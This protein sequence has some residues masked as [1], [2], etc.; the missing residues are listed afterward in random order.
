M[1]ALLC[2]VT[3]AKIA[4][5]FQPVL[6]KLLFSSQDFSREELLPDLSIWEEF[7]LKAGHSCIWR[8][9]FSPYILVFVYIVIVVPQH[10]ECTI[11]RRTSP[12]ILIAVAQLRVPPCRRPRFEPV[13]YLTAGSHGNQC[14]T[15]HPNELCCTPKMSYITS[16]WAT[17]RHLCNSGIGTISNLYKCTL[18][19][20]QVKVSKHA[21][22]IC[23]SQTRATRSTDSHDQ[24]QLAGPYNRR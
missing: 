18:P 6:L 8:R 15:Q 2:M 20:L 4:L 12:F 22:K 19:W 14:A 5:S 10:W 3:V 9:Y 13:T 21:T 16:Q 17:S 11:V 1:Y 23:I 7:N 24:P